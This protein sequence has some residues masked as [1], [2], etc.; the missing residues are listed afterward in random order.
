[1]QAKAV[2]L[3]AR[4]P[5]LAERSLQTLTQ[6]VASP[7]VAAPV[8]GLIIEAVVMAAAP[9]DSTVASLLAGLAI[10]TTGCSIGHSKTRLSLED[11]ATG[12]PAWR[13]VS[14][15]SAASSIWLCTY[16]Q[17][18]PDMLQ[19][20]IERMQLG[21][22]IDSLKV[23]P[24]RFRAVLG[25]LIL[26]YQLC[27]RSGAA[28]DC[29]ALH[30]CAGRVLLQ[31]FCQWWP[32][33]HDALSPATFSVG[34]IAAILEQQAPLLDAARALLKCPAIVVAC[35]NSFRSR[36][37]SSCSS[38]TV[39]AP[40]CQ[41]Q[42]LSSVAATF[43]MFSAMFANNNGRSDERHAQ[44]CGKSFEAMLQLLDFSTKRAREVTPDFAAA[45]SLQAISYELRLQAT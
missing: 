42:F 28:V 2:T 41:A 12:S 43:T 6:L 17:L 5:C 39:P 25:A 14:I 27:Q 21:A 38:P 40:G 8:A 4:L 19:E 11:V 9:D 29:E 10:G 37:E 44:L 35:C 26:C 1:V 23:E 33:E 22:E 20:I 32:A 45:C 34:R 16:V 30:S 7:H 36:L 18:R 31:W 24:A 3:L 13:H 15:V